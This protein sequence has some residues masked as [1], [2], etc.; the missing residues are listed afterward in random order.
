MMAARCRL[1]APQQLVALCRRQL[2]EGGMH[3]I[4]EIGAALAAPHATI[5]RVNTFCVVAHGLANGE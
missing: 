5:L 3:L 2:L 4:F 1:R